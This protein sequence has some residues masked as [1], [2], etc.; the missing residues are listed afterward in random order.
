MPTPI[1]AAHPDAA[2]LAKLADAFDRQLLSALDGADSVALVNFPNHNNPGDSAIWLGARA[3]LRRLG[4][5]VRYQSAWCTYNA[6]ALR[7]ALPD[8]PVL[9]NGGGNFGDLYKGQQ[10]LREQLLAELPGRRLIQLPQSIHFREQR[11]LDRVR[12]LVADHGQVTLMLREQH[13]FDFAGEQF[14]AQTVL[15]PDCA[16]ALGALPAPEAAP[17]VDVLWLHRLPGDPEYV[18]HG[19]LPTDLPVREVE[20]LR[21]VRPEPQWSTRA[22]AARKAN[23]WLLPR[24][25]SDA[26]WSRRAWRPLA[27]TFAPF[28]YGHVQRGLHI[29]A[30]GRVLV[31]DKLHGHLMALLAGIP[32][33][34][35]DNSYGKVSGTYQTW[36]SPSVIAKWADDA[37]QAAKLAH[38]L[39]ESR[40]A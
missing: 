11:N 25:R 4:V 8:G 10:G 1:N 18:D 7:R 24:C 39:F 19:N 34:V 3:S 23:G 6:D 37:E 12:R 5:R 22:R 14:D 32:H 35:L 26:T 28:G 33:V 30:R 36:T 27:A 40:S 15:A 2:L 29:M 31:T 13:S 38:E 20:W 16:L 9:L 21:K 17:D